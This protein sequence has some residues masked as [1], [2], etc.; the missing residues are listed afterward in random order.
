MGLVKSQELLYVMDIVN[1]GSAL[2]VQ[3]MN[4]TGVSY[5]YT[6]PGQVTPFGMRQMHMRGREMRRRFINGE[7]TYLASIVDPTEFWA[8]AIEGDRTYS[9]AMSFMTGFYPGGDE[10]PKLLVVNQT[11]IAKPPINVT[12]WSQENETLQFKALAN[13]FQT[14]PIHSDAGNLNSTIY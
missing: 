11:W 9:S 12:R 3:Y 10:G 13:N 4:F 2:P 6:G 14:V 8:Y 5:D 1:H 7:R